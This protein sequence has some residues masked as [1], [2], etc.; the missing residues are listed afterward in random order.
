MPHSKSAGSSPSVPMAH[1]VK[2]PGAIHQFGG[3]SVPFT[4]LNSAANISAPGD[5]DHPSMDP[6]FKWAS[7]SFQTGPAMRVLPAPGL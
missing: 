5:L 4:L 3:M 2:A 6:R 7:S 1:R